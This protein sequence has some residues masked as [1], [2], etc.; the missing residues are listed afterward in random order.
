VTTIA[1]VQGPSWTVIG[2]DAQVSDE[3]RRYQLPHDFAKLIRNGGYIFG[4]AGDLRAVNLLTH[5]FDPP[6]FTRSKGVSLDK[7]MVSKFIPKLKQCFDGCSY[8]KDGEQGSLVMVC[9]E[10]VT[11][12]IGSYYECIRDEHG[13]Y[14][15]GSGSQF[16]LGAMHVLAPRRG[17]LT[18]EK[19]E[20]MVKAAL[21]ASIAYDSASSE[22]IT[23]LLQLTHS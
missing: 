16:A 23:M 14:A 7:F 17:S 1:S 12:E 10:G 4:I 8:G 21:L 20:S 6:P 11:Y 2:A 3:N 19:A 22:P 13:L 15:I 9:V 18:I 5:D